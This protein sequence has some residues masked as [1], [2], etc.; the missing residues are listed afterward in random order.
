MKI[1]LTIG[2]NNLSRVSC[3]P[4]PPEEI[5]SPMVIPN[6]FKTAPVHQHP[7]QRSA[8]PTNTFLA[9]CLLPANIPTSPHKNKTPPTIKHIEPIPSITVESIPPI[10]NLQLSPK[11]GKKTNTKINRAKNNAIISFE[12]LY[13]GFT[14]YRV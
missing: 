11:I 8:T 6:R 3:Q 5:A 12:V 13:L 1:V 4:L 2:F 14:M 9:Q 7:I 10:W